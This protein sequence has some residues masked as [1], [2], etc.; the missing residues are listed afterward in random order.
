MLSTS[1]LSLVL[2]AALG[3]G[4]AGLSIH[5][6]ANS[7][8]TSSIRAPI[9]KLVRHEKLKDLVVHDQ[10]HAKALVHRGT[11]GKSLS[12]DAQVAGAAI[13][14]L[15]TTYIASMNVGSP[16]TT[17]DVIVD[18]GS[19]NTWVGSGTPFRFTRT[20]RNLSESM[21]VQYGSGF[22]VGFEVIDQVS[23]GG[24]LTIPNQEIGVATASQ[25]FAGVDGIVG[26]GPTDLTEGTVQ[27]QDTI[28]TVTDNLFALGIIP[29]PV[30][31]VSFAP[32]NL[33]FDVNGELVFGGVDTSKFIG[34]LSVFRIT[35][36]SP[37]NAFFGIDAS[38]SFGGTTILPLSPGIVDTGTTLILLATQAFSAY[39]KRSGA[40]PDGAT[41]LLRLTPAQ[42]AALPSLNVIVGGVTFTLTPDAQRWPQQL[43]TAIGGSTSFVYLIV[44]TLGSPEGQGLDFILGQFFLE[45]FYSVFDSTGFV[46]L[47][48]TVFTNATV[49]N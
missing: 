28:P 16:A 42:F 47:A 40:V 45:R 48:P 2:F 41:G 14:N 31:S 13:A 27:G 35:S 11:G 49:N 29:A 9:R 44:N 12:E 10:A 43:N 39:T 32:T 18:T 7:T 38:F 23:F 33:T 6:L 36:S 15:V 25:G 17:Y 22:V 20:T 3:L 24:P 8:E 19:S 1:F 46:G 30:I 5:E 4:V 26:L 21:F 37:A 34:T